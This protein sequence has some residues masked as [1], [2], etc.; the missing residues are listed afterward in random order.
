V[1]RAIVEIGTGTIEPEKLVRQPSQ[2]KDK[3]LLKLAL[4]HMQAENMHSKSSDRCEYYYLHEHG[5]KCAPGP[6]KSSR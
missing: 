1:A 5:T 3:G 4:K 6:K 2:E